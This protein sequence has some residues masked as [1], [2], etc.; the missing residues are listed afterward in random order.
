PL[1]ASVLLSL[2]V[3]VGHWSS[4]TFRCRLSSSRTIIVGRSNYPLLRTSLLLCHIY[5]PQ[6]TTPLY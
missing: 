4:L 2:L 5:V 3:E 6:K 1:K